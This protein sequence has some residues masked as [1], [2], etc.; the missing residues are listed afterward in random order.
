MRFNLIAGK[1]NRNE[2]EIPQLLAAPGVIE[3]SP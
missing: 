1:E 2:N 3:G